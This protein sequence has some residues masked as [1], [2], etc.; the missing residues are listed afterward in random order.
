MWGVHSTPTWHLHGNVPSC[1]HPAGPVQPTYIKNS[2]FLL[3]FASYGLL[4]LRSWTQLFQSG[5]VMLYFTVGQACWLCVP[6]CEQ[7]IPQM[8][9]DVDQLEGCACVKMNLNRQEEKSNMFQIIL[10][11]WILLNTVRQSTASRLDTLRAV[12]HIIYLLDTCMQ[13]YLWS[14]I[15]FV[16]MKC[17]T[18]CAIKQPD[19]LRSN[20]S[21][22][23]RWHPCRCVPNPPGLHSHW[24]FCMF[25]ASDSSY[26]PPFALEKIRLNANNEQ[27]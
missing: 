13:S 9:R 2:F 27:I 11:N 19:S 12:K 3:Q 25:S 21:Q 22:S 7:C 1:R 24:I 4:W 18:I 14:S 15:L 6:H 17:I 8:Q 23:P 10:T 20:F 26:W 5:L 16:I